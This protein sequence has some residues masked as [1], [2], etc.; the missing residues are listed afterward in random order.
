MTHFILDCDDVLLDWE[1][2]FVAYLNARGIQPDPA[3]PQQW[4]LSK[5]LGCSPAS[6]ASWVGLFNESPWFGLLAPRAGAVEFV[7]GIRAAGHTASVLTCCGSARKTAQAR[8]ANLVRVFGSDA[9]R[10]VTVLDLGEKKFDA[11]NRAASAR[12][13]DLVF[14]EDNFMHAQSGVVCGIPSFCLRRS[15]NRRLEELNYGTKVIWVD[16]LHEI[17]SHLAGVAA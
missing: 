8:V 9:F 10:A 4:D 5:W 1:A 3:G 13:T 2:G 11:L 15:H 12:E 7:Q 6:A 14:I 17:L 16:D